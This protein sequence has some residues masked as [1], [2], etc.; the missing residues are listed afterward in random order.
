MNIV[1][2]AISE[3][4]ES[5]EIALAFAVEIKGCI[6]FFWSSGK[7]IK[8]L[9]DAVDILLISQCFTINKHYLTIIIIIIWIILIGKQI[10]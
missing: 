6:I 2:S 4:F 1:Y 3:Q 7:K 9:G 10:S 8:Y 5:R